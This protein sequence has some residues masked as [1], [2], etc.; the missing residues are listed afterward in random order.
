M[1]SSLAIEGLPLVDGRDVLVAE[2]PADFAERI[3]S[4]CTDPRKW[5]A[6]RTFAREKAL[7]LFGRAVVEHAVRNGLGLRHDSPDRGALPVAPAAR[8]SDAPGGPA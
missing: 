8:A 2:E 5:E 3:V 4:L 7:R 1:A 6:Q